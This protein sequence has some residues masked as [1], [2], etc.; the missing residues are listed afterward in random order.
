[1][2]AHRPTPNGNARPDANTAWPAIRR[3]AISINKTDPS[4]RSPDTSRWTDGRCGA[5]SS[6][7]VFP[8]AWRAYPSRACR[9]RS[10]IIYTAVGTKG[11]AMRGSSFERS[12]RRAFKV[13]RA[14][15][16]RRS[17]LG[18]PPQ[19]YRR[20]LS[21][22]CV[23]ERVWLER[24]RGSPSPRQVSFWFLDLGQPREPDFRDRAHTLVTELCARV[25]S[26]QAIRDLGRD[27]MAPVRQRRAKT[28]PAWLAQ[29]QY[30]PSGDLK[31]FARSLASV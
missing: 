14:L 23:P 26:L 28:F 13:P 21:L 3:S 22:Q 20:I 10:G 29:V 1:M 31:A 16:S 9:I 12:W 30:C 24:V 15:C 25:P 7:R 17:I 27:F 11:A 2:P 5:C 8:N 4:A 19:G 18:I 6:P